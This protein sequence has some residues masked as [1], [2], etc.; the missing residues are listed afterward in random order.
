VYFSDPADEAA[1]VQ[2]LTD[3][4]A[5]YREPIVTEVEA[6]QHYWPAED[7]HQDYFLNHPNQGYCAFVVAP[8]VDKVEQHFTQ[9][10]KV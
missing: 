7:Y 3:L 5:N 10:L 9:W 8:K 6:L 4:Q 1:V 2:I